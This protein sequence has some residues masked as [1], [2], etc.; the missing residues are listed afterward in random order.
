[1]NSRLNQKQPG[2]LLRCPIKNSNQQISRALSNLVNL[3]MWSTNCYIQLFLSLKTLCG[4]LS[5]L[6]NIKMRNTNCYP[7]Q[8][9]IFSPKSNQKHLRPFV[10]FTNW[11]FPSLWFGQM[12]VLV[13]NFGIYRACELVLLKSIQKQAICWFHQLRIPKLVSRA[14]CCLLLLRWSVRRYDLCS[15]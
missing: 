14:L 10:T 12:W 13:S 9:Q 3:K 1:M 5:N 2:H 6:A 15:N 4:A 11:Q 7:G 8:Q